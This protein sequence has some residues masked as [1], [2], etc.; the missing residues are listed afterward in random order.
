MFV[1]CRL[2]DRRDLLFSVQ[3]GELDSTDKNKSNKTGGGHPWLH[4]QAHVIKTQAHIRT[5]IRS[6]LQ[7]LQRLSMCVCWQ[8]QWCSFLQHSLLKEKD[9]LSILLIA[10]QQDTKRLSL[11]PQQLPSLAPARVISR[12]KSVCCSVALLEMCVWGGGSSCICP[13]HLHVCLCVSAI[14]RTGGRPPTTSLIL[15]RRSKGDILF[16]I[17]SQVLV[18]LLLPFLISTHCFAPICLN[19]AAVYSTLLHC[20]LRVMQHKS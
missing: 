1:R 20:Q 16:F 9:R 14:T 8:R 2:S 19:T 17:P 7:K 3:T 6:S 12:F 15:P 13:Q 10:T 4:S 5:Q 18:F 11:S